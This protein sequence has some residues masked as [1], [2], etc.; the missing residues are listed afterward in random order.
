M[1][2]C[3]FVKNIAFN[4]ISYYRTVHKPK[5]TF[6]KQKQAPRGLFPFYTNYFIY[7]YNSY[8]PSLITT[9]TGVLFTSPDAVHVIP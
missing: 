6:V 5:K 8:L 2:V 9:A 7:L 3:K 4:I 1:S